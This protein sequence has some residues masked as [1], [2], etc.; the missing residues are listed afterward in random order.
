MK[1]IGKVKIDVRKPLDK[2]PDYLSLMRSNKEPDD[3]E[4]KI[5]EYSNTNNN[6][7]EKIS[8]NKYNSLVSKVDNY[9]KYIK[10]KNQIVKLADNF[11]TK[12]YAEINYSEG[13][14]NLVKTKF[15]LLKSVKTSK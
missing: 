11:E 4:E 9:E 14:I 13:L 5:D 6:K 2:Y 7:T 15:K 12:S 1:S 3:S 10:N 8:F